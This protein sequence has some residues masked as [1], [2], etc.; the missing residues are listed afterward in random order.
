MTHRSRCDKRTECQQ[1][2][3]KRQVYR[4]QK[5]Q[6]TIPVLL[7]VTFD[8]LI[9]LQKT[10]IFARTLA[11][12]A[13]KQYFCNAKQKASETMERNMT[14]TPRQLSKIG[15]WMRDNKGGIIVVNDRKAVEK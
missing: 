9:L 8:T 6:D 5:T 13:K 1:P 4:S 7:L 3:N 14:C 15:L 11:Y 12:S 10:I 2:G